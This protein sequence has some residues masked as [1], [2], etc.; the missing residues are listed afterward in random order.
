MQCKPAVPPHRYIYTC[1]SDFQRAIAVQE[2]RVPCNPIGFV[3]LS[4]TSFKM[5]RDPLSPQIFPS[6]ASSHASFQ[7]TTPSA[8][9]ELEAPP[10]YTPST[11]VGNG[12]ILSANSNGIPLPSSSIPSSLPGDA[13]LLDREWRSSPQPHHPMSSTSN[14]FHGGRAPYKPQADMST[15]LDVSGHPGRKHDGEPGCCFSETGGCCFSSR[16]GCCF[17]DTEGCCFSTTKGCCF[18]ENAGCCFSDHGGCCS[19]DSNGN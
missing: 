3:I 6:T 13:L 11:S 17:S 19:G 18:S 4:G 10:P 7:Q 9:D 1:H 5:K 8:V 14:Y 16:G 2:P 12:A 15:S